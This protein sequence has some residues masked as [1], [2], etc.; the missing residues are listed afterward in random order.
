M[1]KKFVTKD[2]MAHI[3]VQHISP[4]ETKVKQRA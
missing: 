4:H 2:F 3:N 1:I